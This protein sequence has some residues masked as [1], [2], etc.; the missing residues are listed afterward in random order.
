MIHRDDCR[1]LLPYNSSH[2]RYKSTAGPSCW[3]LKAMRPGYS[4][5]LLSRR[6]LQRRQLEIEYSG[7]SP[8]SIREPAL[9]ERLLRLDRSPRRTTFDGRDHPPKTPSTGPL[10]QTSNFFALRTCGSRQGDVERTIRISETCGQR[11]PS[12]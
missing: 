11:A 3:I 4:A 8:R 7:D 9:A 6:S 12:K 10:T 2:C 5:R 1:L